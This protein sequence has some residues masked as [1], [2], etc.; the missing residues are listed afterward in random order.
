MTSPLWCSSK[1][2]R[3]FARFCKQ[4]DSIQEVLS[5]A[6]PGLLCHS[7]SWWQIYRLSLWGK[8]QLCLLWGWKAGSLLV[9]KAVG[10]AVMWPSCPG[11]W[12]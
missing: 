2:L 5:R 1:L 7:L 9:V 3:S 8:A 4:Q 11:S 10:A 12:E 6:G